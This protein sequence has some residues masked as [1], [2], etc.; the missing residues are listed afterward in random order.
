[1]TRTPI[2]TTDAPAPLARFSQGV[3]SGS[4]VQASGQGP[5]DPETGQ[6][7]FIG[8]IAAQ[9]KQT[10]KLVK[11]IL[12]AG[13]ASIG[14]VVMFRVFLTDRAYFAAMNAAYEEFITE[15]IGDGV[16]PA[17]T[18]LMVGLP[19]EGM[20]VEIDALAVVES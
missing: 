1:M 10:L 16:A 11:A 5:L 17:R 18:T 12:A 19:L 6:V 3:R 8:D 7:I 4:I 14:D 20:L 15:E 2:S 13:G 9:T